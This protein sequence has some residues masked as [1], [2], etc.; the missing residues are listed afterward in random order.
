MSLYYISDLVREQ[1]STVPFL[2]QKN[3]MYNTGGVVKMIKI[4][5]SVYRYRRKKGGIIRCEM[6][7]KRRS[8]SLCHP[9]IINLTKYWI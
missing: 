5:H 3:L 4:V 8:R 2:I 7:H 1:F 6:I 9:R